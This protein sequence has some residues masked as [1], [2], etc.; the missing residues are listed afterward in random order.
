MN[1]VWV[2]KKTQWHPDAMQPCAIAQ[3]FTSHTSP[4]GLL[5]DL[6][7]L[8]LGKA[9]H[10]DFAFLVGDHGGDFRPI[11]GQQFHDR[12]FQRDRIVNEHRSLEVNGL[13]KKDGPDARQIGA[14]DAGDEAE[15]DAA[16]RDA[17]SERCLRRKRVVKVNRIMIAGEVR[18]PVDHLVIDFQFLR[19]ALPDVEFGDWNFCYWHFFLLSTLSP[20]NMLPREIPATRAAG[21]VTNVLSHETLA[22]ESGGQ[23]LNIAFGARSECAPAPVF[24]RSDTTRQTTPADNSNC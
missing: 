13:G 7:Q 8:H 15:Q 23:L 12:G 10:D 16:V 4:S 11:L 19:A 20:T 14:E 17:A 21:T 22:N 5:A 1:T 18:V 24:I 2:H 3:R 9:V 6:G